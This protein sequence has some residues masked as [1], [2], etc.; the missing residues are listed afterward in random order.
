[1]YLCVCVRVCVRVYLFV[2]LS[3]FLCDVIWFA[4]VVVV[5]RGP[6]SSDA[7]VAEQ[8]LWATQIL[9]VTDNNR[10]LLA[11]EGACEGEWS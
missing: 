11:A 6:L 8:G 9:A 1:M 2:F 5:L 4:A 10:R 7:V 3:L